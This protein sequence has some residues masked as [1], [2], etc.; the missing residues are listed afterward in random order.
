MKQL[1]HYIFIVS[2]IV[3]M[4]LMLIPSIVVYMFSGVNLM[5]KIQIEA[6]KLERKYF[7][8]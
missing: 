7:D 5:Q 1:A 4:I 8:Q 2:I 6:A 3:F